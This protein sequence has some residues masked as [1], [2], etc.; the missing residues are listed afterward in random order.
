MIGPLRRPRQQMTLPQYLRVKAPRREFEDVI[1]YGLIAGLAICPFWFGSN[2]LGAWGL[3]A[4]LFSS[5]VIALEISFI[6]RAKLHPVP[7][8]Q[9]LVPAIGLGIVVAWVGVQMS[10]L[11]PREWHYPIWGMTADAL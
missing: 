11:T 8:R 3:N 4:I 6:V 2:R 9:I 10:S 1:S 7:I 5:L